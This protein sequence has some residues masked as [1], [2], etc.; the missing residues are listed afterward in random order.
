MTFDEPSSNTTYKTSD[1]S[2]KSLAKES[3]MDT[4]MIILVLIVAIV[5]IGGLFIA[6]FPFSILIALGLFGA[7]YLFGLT[8]K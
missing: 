3:V 8:K 7:L 4:F 1:H 5:V 2:G 6:L